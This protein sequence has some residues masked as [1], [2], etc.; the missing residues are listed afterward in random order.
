MEIV[1][2]IPTRAKIARA[3]LE[4]AH[5][6]DRCVPELSIRGAGQEDRSSGNERSATKETNVAHAPHHPEKPL[7]LNQIHS[8]RGNMRNGGCSAVIVNI[9]RM[10]PKGRHTMNAKMMSHLKDLGITLSL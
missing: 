5:S 7:K 2:P 1:Q 3:W 8:K 4:H 10:F 9:H 6:F